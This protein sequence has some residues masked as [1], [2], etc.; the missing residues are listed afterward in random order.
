VITIIINNATELELYAAIVHTANHLHV[1]EGEV[2]RSVAV[3]YI[4]RHFEQGVYFG[5]DGFVE[6]LKA[7]AR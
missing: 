6:M 3:A 2:T 7:D 4:I 5:W 1:P